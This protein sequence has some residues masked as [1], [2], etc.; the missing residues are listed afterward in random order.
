MR[1]ST[2]RCDQAHTHKDVPRGAT[3]VYPTNTHPLSDG[4][5]II[6]A[7]NSTKVKVTWNTPSPAVLTVMAELLRATFVKSLDELAGYMA[8][9]HAA[10]GATETTVNA[11]KLEENIVNRLHILCKGLRGAA[12]LLGNGFCNLDIP[13]PRDSAATA[14]DEDAA[15]A[16]SSKFLPPL[17]PLLRT[18][19]AAL[20]ASLSKQN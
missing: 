9:M 4:T 18:C 10:Q 15:A 6:G 11:K 12:E 5:F 8:D 7:P 13:M 1:S 20:V 17:P 2:Q 16:A 3:A 14:V 19:A